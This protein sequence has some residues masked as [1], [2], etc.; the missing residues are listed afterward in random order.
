MRSKG[1]II[2]MRILFIVILLFMLSQTALAQGTGE[3]SSP[4]PDT[5]IEADAEA[6]E[7]RFFIKGELAAVLREDGLHVRENIDFGGQTRDMGDK[8]LSDETGDAGG[9]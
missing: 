9:E 3:P 5:R 2:V 7:I 4:L 1:K 8:A 6:D